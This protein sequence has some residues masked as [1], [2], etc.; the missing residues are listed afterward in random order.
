MLYP[1]YC[2][3]SP[4]FCY[5]YYYSA[6]DFALVELFFVFLSFF[7]TL[8]LKADCIQSPEM[9]PHDFFCK[10]GCKF[11]HNCKQMM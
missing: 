10:N 11:E 6:L 2:F 4:F 3:F 1:K 5:W 7:F 9:K 8:N